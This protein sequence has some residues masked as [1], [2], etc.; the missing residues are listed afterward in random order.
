MR[1]KTAAAFLFASSVLLIY[2]QSTKSSPTGL[3]TKD[4][5]KNALDNLLS[6]TNNIDEGSPLKEELRIKRGANETKNTAKKVSKKVVK[7]LKDNKDSAKKV[8]KVVKDNKKSLKSAAKI[9]KGLTKLTKIIIGVV[10]GI[11]V[12]VILIGLAY[13]FYKKK[14]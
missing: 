9:G 13:Y 4:E 11:I 7:V 14:E 8:V 2:F 5:E 10:V 3:L 12:L 1:S 6:E